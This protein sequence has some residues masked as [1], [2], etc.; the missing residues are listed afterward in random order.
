MALDVEIASQVARNQVLVVLEKVE[1]I[2]KVSLMLMQSMSKSGYSG[3]FQA[4]RPL[5][6]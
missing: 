5:S 2:L 6:P 4:W 3:F 1:Q